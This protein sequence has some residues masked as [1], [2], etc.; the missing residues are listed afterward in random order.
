M[1]QKLLSSITSQQFTEEMI[2]SDTSLVNQS[3]FRRQAPLTTIS[4]TGQHLKRD[5]DE[6]PLLIHYC[7]EKRFQSMKRGLHLIYNDLLDQSQ[8]GNVKMI[9]GTRNRR[10]ARHELIRKRP[11]ISLLKDKQRPST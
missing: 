8:N 9:V 1:H 10:S 5:E 7:Y 6:N 4:Q 2:A 11:K 3:T